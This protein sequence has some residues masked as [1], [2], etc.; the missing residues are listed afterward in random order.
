MGGRRDRKGDCEKK[1]K[2]KKRR[3][4]ERILAISFQTVLLKCAELLHSVVKPH[5]PSALFRYCSLSY[6]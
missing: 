3:R 1:K 5:V 6:A 4:G 2:K